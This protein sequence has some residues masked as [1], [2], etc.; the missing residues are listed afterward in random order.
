MNSKKKILVAPLDW[1]LG[2]A[3]RCIP[4]ARAL[5]KE[6]YEVIFAADKR[7]LRL[8]MDE[9]PNNHFIKLSGY[10]VSYPKNGL[11]VI[12]ML[13][14]SVKILKNI[15]REQKAL[16]QI[17][18]DYKID[19]VISDNRYGLYS[20]DIPSIFITHQLKIQSP[21]L[22]DFIQKINYRYISNF[23]E[24]WVP[25]DSK[26]SLS[27]KLS[28]VETT[29]TKTKYIGS[30]S[31]FKKMRQ[32][33]KID[34]LAI[35]SGPE[36][37]RS[38][39]ENLLTKQ[40]ISSQKNALL[41]SGKPEEKRNHSEGKLTVVSHLNA[42]EL[43]QAMAN[44]ELVICRPGYSTIMDLAS[45]EKKAVFIPTP[46]QTEQLYLAKY[47]Y[48]KKSAF[49]MHQNEFDIKIAL[50]KFKEFEGIKISETKPDWK[51]LFSFF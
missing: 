34:I 39:F 30:L 48:Q 12:S 8:L 31:R 10:D 40:L 38:L 36:P 21:I 25:D 37:Q 51:E 29:P 14:Q 7:P 4:I 24:C 1:G 18:R 20:K 9:F 41:V 33:Q 26:N 13:F 19:G 3:T 11:M 28:T 16:K 22:E 45:L 50:T 44:A 46:G 6:G 2:H 5:E 43:N 42:M 47:F 17:I 32:D 35:V 27:G 23:D 49:A 15:T